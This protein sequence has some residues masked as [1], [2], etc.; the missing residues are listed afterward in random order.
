MYLQDPLIRLKISLLLH[1]KDQKYS[2]FPTCQTTPHNQS[3]NHGSLS[4]VEDQV[5]FGLLSLQMITIIIT[6]TIAMAGKDIRMRENMVFQGLWPL[7]L[8]RKQLIV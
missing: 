8:M 6:T 3:W 4:M 7:I 1:Q 2:I 5:G